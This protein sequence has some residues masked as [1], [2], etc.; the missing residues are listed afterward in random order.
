MPLAVRRLALLALLGL[1]AAAVPA[2]AQAAVSLE[3][4]GDFDRPIDVVSPPGDTHRVLVVERDGQVRLVKDGVVQSTSFL[5]IRSLVEAGIGEGGLLSIAIA[6]DYATTGRFYAYYTA[7]GTGATSSCPVSTTDSDVCPP[8][9]IDEFRSSGAG[10][11]TASAGTRRN[12]M[13]IAHP[14]YQNHYGGQLQFDA[15]GHLYIGVGDGGLGGDPDRNGQNG[16]TLLGKILRIDPRASGGAPYTV[17]RDNPFVGFAG[18]RPELWAYGL[19]NPF[20]FSLDRGTGDLLIGDV[21]QGRREEVDRHPRGQGAGR[22][23]NFGWNLCEGNLRYPVDESACPLN[24]APYVAPIHDY[25]HT[26]GCA[27][28]GGYVVRDA[29]LEELSGKYLF[30]DYCRTEVRRLDLPG[31][32]AG[33]VPVGRGVAN[34]ASFGE[35]ACARVYTAEL[36][37]GVVSRLTDGTS[38][39]ST[40]VGLPPAPPTSLGPVTPPGGGGGQ[41]GSSGGGTLSDLRSP[42]L[43]LRTGLRQR[44]L[45]NHGIIVRVRCDEACSFRVGGRLSLRRAG[46]K[47]GLREQTGTLVANKTARLR[48]R[49]SS[50][51]SRALRRALRRKRRVRA[52]VV[53]RVRD[54]SGNLTGGNRLLGLVR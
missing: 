41:G 5:D 27:I 1:A 48:L 53:I 51:S 45:R 18:V 24:A 15:A 13:Q 21:G 35:D 3:K 50:P 16:A 37:S 4:V 33:T 14:K 36:S 47:I 44:P 39:C 54:G 7:A 40:A 2:G 46:R 30:A 11:D 34:V 26:D 23:R 49:L 52:R 32:A 29:S 19:R 38:A 28:T 12:V 17:P 20:R 42:L 10:A 9:R 6:P 25:E 8:I 22:G 43:G 31:G